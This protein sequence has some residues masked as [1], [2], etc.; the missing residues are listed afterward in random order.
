MIGTFQM[1]NA[2]G[3]IGQSL[4]AYVNYPRRTQDPEDIRAVLRANWA[5]I[6]LAAVREDFQPL[7]RA[8]LLDE[9]LRGLT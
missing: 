7:D 3:L 8:P 6:D 5:P 9:I 4:K 2:E 1:V